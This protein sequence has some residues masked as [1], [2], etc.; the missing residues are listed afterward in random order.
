MDALI[1]SMYFVLTAVGTP[2]LS[3]HRLSVNN[4]SLEYIFGIPF[5]CM[6]F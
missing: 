1:G 5:K 3:Y 2:M 4:V 6:L